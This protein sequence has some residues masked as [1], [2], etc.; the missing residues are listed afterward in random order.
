M[1]NLSSGV[2]IE[3]AAATTGAGT[4]EIDG[5]AIDMQ[6]FDGVLFIAKFGTAAADN[7]IQA[8]QGAAANLSDAADLLGT[9]VGVGA[10]DEI[11]WLDITRPRERYVRIQGLRGTSTTLDWAVAIK[12]GPRKPPVDNTI[13]GTIHGEAHAS[14]AEGTV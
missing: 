3:Q 5:A 7:S 8:Q 14:P 4:S 9:L 12:Y 6:N 1:Q 11:V 13:A 10:S 2:K